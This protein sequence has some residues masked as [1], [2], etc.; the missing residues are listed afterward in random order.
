M[1]FIFYFI[2]LFFNNSIYIRLNKFYEKIPF[3]KK[4]YEFSVD[5][6]IGSIDKDTKVEEFYTLQSKNN[7]RGLELLFATYGRANKGDLKI[8]VLNVKNN[9]LIADKTINQTQIKDNDYVE[10]IFPHVEND[11]ENIKILITSSSEKAT[12]VTMWKSTKVKNS[13]NTLLINGKKTNGD[14]IIKELHKPL[15]VKNI[16]FLFTGS[17]IIAIISFI[18][19]KRYE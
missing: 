15:F 2:F 8:R 18:L 10:I 14:L 19:F 13:K 11:L 6:P 9:K 3:Q 4:G 7:V 16:I 17:I 5:E 1:F 12:S